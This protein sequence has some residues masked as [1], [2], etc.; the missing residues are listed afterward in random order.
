MPDQIIEGLAGLIDPNAQL[1]KLGDGFTF[2]EG[3]VWIAAEQRL[4]F[5]DIPGDARWRWSVTD[6][7]EL[8]I[9]P[10]FKGNGM[11][12]DID[13]NLV[14]CEHVSSS[15]SRLRDGRRETL[16]YHYRGTYLNSPNDVVLRTADGSLYFSDP[17]IGRSNSHYG[18][19]RAGELPFKGVFRIPPQAGAELELACGEDDFERPNGLCFSPDQS[20]LYINDSAFGRIRRYEVRGDGSL[21]NGRTLCEGI[22]SG[23]PNTG[24]VDGMKC[25][26]LGNIW[27]TGPGGVWVLTPDGE[28]LGKLFT[29]QSVGN[30][31]WGGHD[32]HTL[33]LMTSSSVHTLPTIVGPAA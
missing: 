23:I 12:L 7:I 16:A 21:T 24:N 31:A 4:Y 3:P 6:G 28:P 9:R 2:T 5:S 22:G 14:V 20:I 30:F 26:E 1:T 19:E 10:T 32:L 15:V 8:V 18:L 27:V 25:D 29:P 13:G 11:C 17:L 33:F